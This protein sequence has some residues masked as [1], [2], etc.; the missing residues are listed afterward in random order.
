M[1]RWSGGPAFI[2]RRPMRMS[3]R[4]VVNSSRDHM[5]SLWVVTPFVLV[6]CKVSEFTEEIMVT[7]QASSVSS[8]CRRTR[9]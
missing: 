1:L 5:T 9:N 6:T 2:P 3:R 7:I 4:L 8:C